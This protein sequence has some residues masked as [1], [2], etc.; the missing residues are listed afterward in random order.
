ME[1]F[2]EVLQEGAVI[3]QHIL[4]S[5]NCF[6]QHSVREGEDKIGRHLYS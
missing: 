1:M 2:T 5:L 6:H 4:L 3:T